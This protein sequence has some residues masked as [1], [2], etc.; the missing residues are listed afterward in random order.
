MPAAAGIEIEPG[1]A[2]APAVPPLAAGLSAARQGS[3]GLASP[4]VTSDAASFHAQWQSELAAMS[5][6]SGEAGGWTG[7]GEPGGSPSGPAGESKTSDSKAGESRTSPASNPQSSPLPGAAKLPAWRQ[8]AR[9]NPLPEPKSALSGPEDAG[10]TGVEG[11][12]SRSASR[13]DQNSGPHAKQ[14]SAAAAGAQQLIGMVVVPPAAP[15]PPEGKPA[16][17]PAAA[18]AAGR[19]ASPAPALSA[20]E[21]L[22]PAAAGSGLQQGSQAIAAAASAKPADFALDSQTAS[23]AA[24]SADDP[25]QTESNAPAQSGAPS[26]APSA[27]D[28]ANPASNPIAA[29]RQSLAERS[30]SATGKGVDEP[31]NL[32]PAHGANSPDAAAAA[33]LSPQALA[34]QPI[35]SVAESALLGRDGSAPGHSVNLQTLGASGGAA[36]A[37][38]RETFAAMDS[39]S[40]HATSWIHAGSHSAEAGFEDPSLG[41]IGV[42]ADMGSGG[43]HASVVPGSAAAAAMLGGHMAGLHAYLSDHHPGVET[44]SLASP[45]S[46]SGNAGADQAMQQQNGQSHPEQGSRSAQRVP[47]TPAEA[48]PSRASAATASNADAAPITWQS[49]HSISV[50]A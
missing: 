23:T 30:S 47:G 15:L 4:G 32:R 16:A 46:Q 2:S 31:L 29:A 6:H 17:H 40:A 19:A 42:R 37:A 5:E 33:W 20:R 7:S 11:P 41:W 50:V 14:L 35:P 22:G 9:L 43:V 28:D 34:A 12:P 10:S 48:E 24:H 25:A 3:G 27:E 49:G 8:A 36:A 21:H 1:T 18:P 45:Q 26:G 39:A 38:P 13:T 44:L